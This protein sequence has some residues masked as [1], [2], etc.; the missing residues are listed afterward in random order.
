MEWNLMEQLI[1]YLSRG[2]IVMIPLLLCSVI[3]LAI[4]IEKIF[5]LRKRKILIPEIVS[6]VE[7]IETQ[8]DIELAKRVCEKHRGPFANIL[9]VALNLQAYPKE[10]IKELTEEQGRQEVRSLE[11]GLSVME[12][13]AGISPLLGLLGTV[14]GMIKVFTVIST[15]GAGQ[16]KALAG[17]ISEA[18]ITTATGLV[19][20]IPILVAFNY[21]TNRAENFILDIE[22][23]STR[24][25]QKIK[26][27]QE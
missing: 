27:I 11:K 22:K 7:S 18:L 5:V 25:V 20:G 4:I 6:V 26:R 13:I 2:G 14:I 8:K 19:I 16:A 23:Y 3:G 24:L 21:F 12:T 15:Q 17:G 1:S 9:L 10:E